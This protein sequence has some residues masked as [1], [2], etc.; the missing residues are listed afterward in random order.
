MNT[1]PTDARF[2]TLLD[3]DGNPPCDPPDDCGVCVLFTHQ[4]PGESR[5]EWLSRPADLA[6]DQAQPRSVAS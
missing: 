5:A 3:A 6:A 4:R 1:V 2:A